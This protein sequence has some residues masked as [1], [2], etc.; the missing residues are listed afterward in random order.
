VK[1]K[2]FSEKTVISVT[3]IKARGRAAV[4][5]HSARSKQA[6]L[7]IGLDVTFS[8]EGETR[9]ASFGLSIRKWTLR[10]ANAARVQ[11]DK[12]RTAVMS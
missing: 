7:D 8:E 1:R 11:A 3:N 5:Q 10:T 6:L 2:D 12:P 9:F 4:K